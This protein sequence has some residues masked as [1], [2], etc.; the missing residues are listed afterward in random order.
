MPRRK[1]RGMKIAARINRGIRHEKIQIQN[2][3]FLSY[4]EFFIP[5]NKFFN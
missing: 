2:R 4:F 5:E 1:S 3:K